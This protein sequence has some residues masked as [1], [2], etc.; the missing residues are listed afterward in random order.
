[1]DAG[2]FGVEHVLDFTGGFYA[3]EDFAFEGID[4]DGLA[5]LVVEGEPFGD[6]G[7]VVI[8]GVVDFY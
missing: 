3:G 2:E 6:Q 7:Q 4:C 1:M 8:D 5:G